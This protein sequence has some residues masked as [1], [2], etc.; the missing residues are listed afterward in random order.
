MV[1]GGLLVAPLG[2]EPAKF[3]GPTASTRSGAQHFNNV[4]LNRLVNRD[5]MGRKAAILRLKRKIWLEQDKR[6]RFVSLT[7]AI[8]NKLGMWHDPI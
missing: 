3:S 4:E 2:S 1:S 7:G 8:Q 6:S 5:C